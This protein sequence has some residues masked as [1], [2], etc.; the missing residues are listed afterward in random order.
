MADNK[1]TVQIGPGFLGILTIVFIVLKLMGVI[2]WSWLWVL[3]PLWIP[4]LVAVVLLLVFLLVAAVVN[5]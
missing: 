1:T 3:A 5:R 4:F 2:A